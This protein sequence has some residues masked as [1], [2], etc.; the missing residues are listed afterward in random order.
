MSNFNIKYKTREGG[1]TISI[2]VPYD[3]ENH[4]PFCINK[5]EYKDIEGSTTNILKSLDELHS[6]TPSC[7][8]V[9]T[10]G[11]PFA[12]LNELSYILAHISELNNNG[13]TKHKVFINTSLPFQNG[14]SDENLIDF[15]KDYSSV[16]TGIN[17]S[18]HIFSFLKERPDSLLEDLNE[19][20]SVRINCVLYPEK[21]IT[22]ELISKFIIRFYNFNIQFRQDYMKTTISNMTGD[23]DLFRKIHKGL[24]LSESEI[25]VFKNDSC[26]IRRGLYF[27]LLS[28]KFT[29]FHLTL[30]YSQ[31]KVPGDDGYIYNVLYDI[32]IKQNGEIHADWDYT[33]LDFDAYKYCIENKEFDNN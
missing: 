25:L 11:E 29:S 17:V 12:N 2:F 14:V 22:P 26:R 10:G 24:W 31:I 3:C 16:I 5:K 6:L 4:C 15:I 1:A 9:L 32:I 28:G 33:E 19:I 20:T 18:R 27:N 7:D 23:N 8:I 13:D 30:P 21:D